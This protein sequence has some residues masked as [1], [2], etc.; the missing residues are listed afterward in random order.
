M[1]LSSEDTIKTRKL[2]N[3]KLLTGRKYINETEEFYV[4]IYEKPHKTKM[5][6]KSSVDASFKDMVN[7]HMRYSTS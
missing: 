2:K 4:R 5:L 3:G 7:K 1:K 6:G